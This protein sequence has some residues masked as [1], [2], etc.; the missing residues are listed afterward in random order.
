MKIKK[1]IKRALRIPLYSLYYVKNIDDADW[2]DE[3]E[4][5]VFQKVYSQQT[6]KNITIALKWGTENASFNFRS[7]L[8]SMPQKNKD[9]YK[10]VCKVYKVLSIVGA[11]QL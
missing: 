9:I 5:L 6:I 11:R 1:D 4:I 3:D 2:L 7:L 8:P 10:Y